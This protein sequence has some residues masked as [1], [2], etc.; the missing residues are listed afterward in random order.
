MVTQLKRIN[1]RT[2]MVIILTSIPVFLCSLYLTYQG[3]QLAFVPYLIDLLLTATYANV[4]G[5]LLKPKNK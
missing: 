4:K 2:V 5:V 1:L 3:I